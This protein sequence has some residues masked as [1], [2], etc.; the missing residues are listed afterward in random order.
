[1]RGT[2]SFSGDGATVTLAPDAPFTAGENVMVILSHDLRGTDGT[3]LRGAGYSYQFWTRA[4]GHSI[5]FEEIDVMTTRTVPQT[6]TRSYGGL[7]SD[8]DGDGWMDLTIVNEDS[9]DLRVFLN[10]GAGDGMFDPFLTPPTPVNDRASPSE[11][12]DF[13]RDGIVDICVANINTQSVSIVLGNGDGTFQPQQEVIVGASPRGI[14]VLDVDG[15]GDIDIVNTNA[16]GNNCS[17]LINDGRGVFA[18]PIYFEGGGSSEWALAAGDLNEDGILDLV[19]GAR[20]SQAIIVHLGNGDGT[21]TA[22]PAEPGVGQMWMLVLGDVDGDGHEDVATVNSGNNNGTIL[23]GF[24]NGDLA[25][26][27]DHPTD[28]FPLATDLGDLDGDGDLDWITS[29]FNGDW[30]VFRNDGTG[31]FG[32]AVEFNAPNAA[33]C[34]LPV[35]IDNDGD[36]DLALIDEL[37]D[38]V[39]LMRNTAIPA[40]LD[41][42]G[43]VGPADLAVLLAEWGPCG[44][45]AADLDGD[46]VVGP[47]DLGALLANWTF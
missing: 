11:P 43:V 13:N 3:F 17:V 41:G 21:F 37:A 26:L 2:Y 34:S 33:S 39:I 25:E 32:F 24:G 44:A 31:Q 8:L 45:C 38:V 12:S 23:R 30:F 1:M 16:G 35:D 28:P 18:A 10:Q 9:A 36:L 20:V 7:A 29:S 14:A 46:G 42:D 5:D 6:T 19:V 27:A 15:D 4:G 22:L 47:A 40:D